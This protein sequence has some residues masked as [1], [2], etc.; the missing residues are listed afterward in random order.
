MK[1]LTVST[2]LISWFVDRRWLKYQA[3][4]TALERV[5]VYV[6]GILGYFAV[7]Y[8]IVPL[9]PAN[10]AGYVLDRFIRLVYVMLIVP[11]IISKTRK[12]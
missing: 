4:G 6:A 3:V 11:F 8:I 12:A 9:L 1:R 2:I 5:T 10:I 7:V